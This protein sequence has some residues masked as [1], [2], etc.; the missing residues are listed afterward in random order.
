MYNATPPAWA[1]FAERRKRMI[2]LQKAAESDCP[3]LHKL[4]QEAFASLLEKYQDFDTNPAAEGL[5]RVCQRF[6]QPFTDYYLILLDRMPVGMLRV[7]DF[8]DH[9][10]L[11][12]IC[13]LPR[14]QGRG[15]AQQAMMLME[16]LYPAAKEW[17][18]DT[19]VQEEKLCRLYEKLGYRRTGEYKTIK[20][21]MDLVFYCKGI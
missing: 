17:H 9:C 11:S 15:F 8:G 20:P 21:G 18:L 1:A 3:L 10:R 6:A 12:P 19:I 4:Q 2:T 7:C 16:G 13:I 14:Y 5:D